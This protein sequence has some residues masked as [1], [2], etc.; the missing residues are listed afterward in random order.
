MFSFKAL[1][2]NAG[3]CLIGDYTALICLHETIHDVN[4][5]SSLIKD[6][7]GFF[8]GFAYDV[9]KAYEKQRQIIEP[10]QFYEEIGTRFGVEILWPTLFLYSA[11]LRGSL[12]FM[13]SSKQHQAMTYALEYL[14]E[15]AVKTIFPENSEDILDQWEHINVKHPFALEA[16]NSRGYAFCKMTGA[17]RKSHLSGIVASL[18]PTYNIMYEHWCKSSP[19]LISPK[20]YESY[21]NLEWPDPKW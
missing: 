16:I 18:S 10:P 3:I 17:K 21:S 13:D 9:R 11:L 5:K 12:A 6:K 1:K 20:T 7:E 19:N 2:N 15:N 4:K 8:L 14:I